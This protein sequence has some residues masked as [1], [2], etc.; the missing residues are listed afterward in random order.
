MGYDE[1][2]SLHSS[3]LIGDGRTLAYTCYARGDAP[4][5]SSSSSAD[6]LMFHFDALTSRLSKLFP[7]VS[8]NPHP[9]DLVTTPLPRMAWRAPGQ[10]SG[11]SAAGGEASRSLSVCVNRARTALS[12]APAVRR[13][14]LLLHQRAYVHWYTRYGIEI[15]EMHDA[16]DSIESIMQ[17]YASA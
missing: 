6:P 16:V 10:Q 2:D 1:A 15:D 3:S 9:L 8:W 7:P 11:V 5:S 12:L 17:D 4:S 14:R 13:A